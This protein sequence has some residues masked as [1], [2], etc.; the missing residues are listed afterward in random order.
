MPP[1]Y[2]LDTNI[3]VHLVRG[4]AVGQHIQKRYTPALID[5]RPIIS[6]VTEGEL[7]SLTLQFR[8]GKSKV[9]QSLFYLSY[10]PRIPIDQQEMVEAHAALDAYSVSLGRAIGKN[11]LWIAA[12]AH[13]M[14]A[15]I[16]TTD[17]DFEHLTP[18][19]LNCEWID[20][21]P[22]EQDGI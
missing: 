2:L 17:R 18:Q 22:E 15:T 16:L 4:D 8:W 9:E 19:F 6:I 3:L 1:L 13:L 12:T 7:R 14:G 20:S 21:V 10:F 11:D 5:P